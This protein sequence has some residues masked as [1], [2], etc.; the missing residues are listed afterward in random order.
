M[1]YETAGSEMQQENNTIYSA[2]F[3]NKSNVEATYQITKYYG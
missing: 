3:Q 2:N 1:E